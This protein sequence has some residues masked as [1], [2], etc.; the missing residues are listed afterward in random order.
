[1][2]DQAF[3]ILEH[4]FAFG[5]RIAIIIDNITARR[6]V[7]GRLFDDSDRLPHFFYPDQ[8]AGITIPIGGGRDFEFKILI[9][10][11]GHFFA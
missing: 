4:V 11:I 2:M 5:N 10:R 7:V 3:N 8:I 9:A 1:M 6:H